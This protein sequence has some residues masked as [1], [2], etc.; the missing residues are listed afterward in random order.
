MDKHIVFDFDGTIVDSLGL[1]VNL[2][3]QMCHKYN[4]RPIEGSEIKSLKSLSIP[5][6]IKLFN[7]PL[8]L[9]PKMGV[10]FKRIYQKNVDHLREIDGIQGIILELKKLGYPLSIISSN[11]VAN[12]Q[13][14]LLNTKIDVFDHIYSSKA[15]FG[16]Q[17]IINQ[18]VKKLNIKKDQMIYIGDELRD[19][20]SCRKAGVKIIAVTWGFDSA[21]LLSSGNP[22]YVANEPNDIL[23]IIHQS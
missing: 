18:V 19:I 13:Q 22:D 2:Y 1:A 11:S 14:F 4:L 10:E 23:K 7:V 20:V 12:I 5:E 21:E 15:L 9:L 8:Y 3:N 17:S 6:L 16:K